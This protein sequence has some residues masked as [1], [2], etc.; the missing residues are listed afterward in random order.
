MHYN[1]MKLQTFSPCI[2]PL[3]VK[4]IIAVLTVSEIRL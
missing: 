4:L 2:R 3:Q 1:K